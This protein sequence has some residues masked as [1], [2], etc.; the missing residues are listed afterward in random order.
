[1]FANKLKVPMHFG[2]ILN[3]PNALFSLNS[4]HCELEF[5]WRGK[6]FP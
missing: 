4:F 2:I 6:Y 1:M 3:V 5:V